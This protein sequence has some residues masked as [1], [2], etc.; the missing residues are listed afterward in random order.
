MCCRRC[1]CN[2]G[3]LRI[4]FPPAGCLFFVAPFSVLFI[5]ALF[6]AVAASQSPHHHILP[7]C[8]CS[9]TLRSQDASVWAGLGSSSMYE[10]AE[11]D[12]K[13]FVALTMSNSVSFRWHQTAISQT[14]AALMEAASDRSTWW[15]LSPSGREKSQVR[16]GLMNWMLFVCWFRNTVVHV[17]GPGCFPQLTRL[18]PLLDAHLVN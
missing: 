12:R 3:C 13:L 15:Y 8:S 7:P 9:I 17:G 16:E 10:V 2:Y 6:I 4:F 5:S 14:A 11:T 1:C 18:T